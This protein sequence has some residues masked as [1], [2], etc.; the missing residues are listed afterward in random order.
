LGAFHFVHFGT[1]PLTPPS[2]MSISGA[3]AA[4]EF[5]TVRIAWSLSLVTSV[6]VLVRR[7]SPT[8]SL[9]SFNPHYH[10]WFISF[11]GFCI[12]LKPLH[13]SNSLTPAKSHL[14]FRTRLISIVSLAYRSLMNSSSGCFCALRQLPISSKLAPSLTLGGLTRKQ[15]RTDEKVSNDVSRKMQIPITVNYH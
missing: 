12:K 5:W 6:L 2:F 10:T 7:Y 11:R 9:S 13:N 15:S 1:P 14:T 4:W 3:K 8:L